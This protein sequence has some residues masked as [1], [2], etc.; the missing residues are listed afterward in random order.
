IT[1]MYASAPKEEFVLNIP[2]ATPVIDSRPKHDDQHQNV[3]PRGRGG[4]A[5]ISP[6][7]PGNKRPFAANFQEYPLHAFRT[8]ANY[9]KGFP[10][11]LLDELDRDLLP[12]DGG[13]QW[14]G[15]ADCI[16]IDA[17]QDG[18]GMRRRQSVVV[19]EPPSIPDRLGRSQYFPIEASREQAAP[20]QPSGSAGGS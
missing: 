4:A 8:S 6:S 15:G 13:G 17:N 1:A 10:K 14:V 2:S 5:A 11:K 19:R 18:F 3:A 9:P 16:M 20:E 7:L 12:W